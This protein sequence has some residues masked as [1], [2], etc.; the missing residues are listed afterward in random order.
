MPRPRTHT[1]DSLVEAAM[2]RFWRYGYEATSID[3]L[4]KA[5]GV[6][7]HGIY[8]DIGGKRELFLEG[9]EAY[10]KI[11][12]APALAK[13]NSSA[14][15]I[16]GIRR[17]FETQ[18]SLAESGE[19][20][21]P[22][23]LVANAMTETAPHDE[24]VAAKVAAHNKHLTEAFLNAVKKAAPHLDESENQA[25]AAFLTLTAQGLWSMSRTIDRASELRNYVDT[26][27]NILER[28]MQNEPDK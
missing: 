18:T 15:G 22:G 23:C 13:M 8:S 4:V 10:Q 20:P 1:R 5:T 19:L 21:G 7:R 24:G 28:R 17:Y 25:L 11:I 3:D 12:V 26:L 2:H 9:F 14:S 6:S 27:M 16:S